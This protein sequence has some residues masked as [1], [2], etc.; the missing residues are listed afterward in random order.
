MKN[1]T[2]FEEIL[3]NYSDNNLLLTKLIYNTL[4][5]NQKESFKD[6]FINLLHYDALDCDSNSD[7]EYNKFILSIL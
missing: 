7:N 1:T 2:L 5:D 3:D 4:T 6:W